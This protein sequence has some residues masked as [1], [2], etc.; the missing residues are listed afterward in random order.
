MKESIT[1]KTKVISIAHITNV[2]GDIRPI[3]KIIKYAHEHNILVIID[4][5]TEFFDIGEGE[6]E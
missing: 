1:D 4:E 2:V 3:K 5:L 6:E